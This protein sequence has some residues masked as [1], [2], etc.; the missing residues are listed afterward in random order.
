MMIESCSM[1][2][3]LCSKTYRIFIYLLVMCA[4]LACEE[5][6]TSNSDSMGTN[7]D[8]QDIIQ[9]ADATADASLLTDQLVDVPL[10]SGMMNFDSSLDAGSPHDMSRPMVELASCET[11][12]GGEPWEN[13][14]VESQEGFEEDL[15]NISLDALPEEIDL[16]ELIPLFK[17]LVAYTLDKDITEF[18]QAIQK[19]DLL[20]RGILGRVVAAS[21]VLGQMDPLGIDFLF[22]RRGLHRYYH[23]DR[24][25]PVTLEGFKQSIFDYSDE[26][27]ILESIAKCGPR[28]I[29]ADETQGVYVAETVVDGE[30]RETEIILSGRRQD[31]NLDFLI[32]NSDGLLSD[33]TRFPTLRAG[34][35]VMAASPYVCTSCHI[36]SEDNGTI[37]YDLLFP[38]IGPCK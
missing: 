26:T 27:E 1:P 30:V 25:F 23:C 31:G 37:R 34:S 20:A 8:D 18:D 13:M 15:M 4:M 17:G 10:D 38:Q 12:L 19:R 32:Y 16:S 2:F 14:V 9:P 33:R 35:E 6:Q 22:L 21:L 28:N 3:I 7:L 24:G 36:N 11:A 29:F 5:T